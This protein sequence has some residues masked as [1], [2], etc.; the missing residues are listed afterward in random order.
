MNRSS[1]TR[2][3]RFLPI[4][5]SALLVGILA[6]PANAEALSPTP[7]VVQDTIRGTV[8]DADTRQPVLG[9]TV[10][11]AGTGVGTVT[12]AEGNY[13]LAAPADGSLI[14]SRI[15]YR[16]LEVAIA[17]RA[18]V[19]VVLDVSVAELQEL[20]VTGYTGQRRADIT[21]AVSS[22]N[23]ESAGRETSSSVLQRLHGNVPGVTVEASGTPGA[24]S[25]VRIRGISS[26]QNNNPLY[27][28]DGIPVEDSG[29]ANYLNP[30]DIESI[31]VLKDASA[32]SIYGSR[33]N[34]GV[35]IIE[36]KK[37]RP[38]PPRVSVDA[39]FG[40]ATPVRGYDSF[41]IQDA[42]EYHEV[43][44]LSHVNAGLEVPTNIF[45]DPNNPSLPAYTYVAPG[46]TIGTDE[47]GR[48]LA[49]EGMYA[50]PDHLIMPASAGTNWWDAVFGTAQV[51]DV[52]LRVSGGSS[53]ERYNVSFNYFDQEGT[54]AFTRFQRGTIRLNT[55]FNVGRLTVGE[56]LNLSLEEGFG[57]MSDPGGFAENTIIGKNMMMQPV[58]PVRDVAGNYASAKAIG[59][60]NHTNPL[61]LAESTKDNV[62]RHARMLGNAFARFDL[63]DRLLVNTRFGFNVGQ[64]MFRGFDDIFPENSEPVLSNRVFESQ[65][66]FLNWTW[67]NTLNYQESF[68]GVHNTSILVGQEANRNSGRSMGGEIR[69]LRFTTDINARYIQDAIGDPDTKN[70]SSGGGFSTLLSYF[71]K[72]DYNFDERYY[73]SF[74]L[75]H[76]GSS[77]LGPANRWGTFP[78]FS[79]G[80]RLS[81]EPFLERSTFFTNIMLRA[82]WGITGNQDI[83]A[84]RTVDR[85]GGSIGD[86]FYDID[87]SGNRVVLG[88]RQT[89]WGNP[90]LKWEENQSVNLG[91]DLEFLEG[92]AHLEL[93]VYQ[94]DTDNLL[95]NPPLPGTAGQAASRIVNIGKMSNRGIDFAIGY[96][97]TLG[98]DVDWHVNFNGA[99]YRNE[100]VRI[101]GQ[102][103]FFFGPIS[104]RFGTHAINMVGYPIGAFY[105]LILDG[106]FQ[107]Q[108]EIDALNER[109]RQIT[110]DPDAV[111][112]DGAAPGRFRFRD[113]TGDG[114][115]TA[116]DRTIIGDPHPDFTAGLNL[117]VRWNN[118]DLGASLFGTFGNDIFDVQ[119]EF[120][121]FRNFNSNV[122]RDVLSQ[123]AV[124]NEAG[125]VSNPD[126]KY[127]RL[128]VTDEFS[129]AISSFYVEDGSY[130]RLR[131]LQIGYTVPPGRF[132]GLEN[133][134]I[135][136]Q[137]ENLFTITGY[138]GLDPALPASSVSS[139]GMDIRDQARGIDRGAYPSNR[140]F[141]LGFGV[142]F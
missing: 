63:T 98:N 62:S 76:D 84:G 142:A 6:Y 117:G 91:L 28:I 108:A 97:G 75:R 12:D 66:T 88:F 100:V 118:W 5:V 30:N 49:D 9:V 55:E 106:I 107:N 138:S 21:G 50:W 40:M 96:R 67:S 95:F 113:V 60:G 78:A 125:E 126:A 13:S 32:A 65:S 25:T 127:P 109:A 114:R 110:G 37:G 7:G 86:T 24:R 3:T 129:R 59:L 1:S 135:Y 133:V 99:H 8:T 54:A 140:T 90:D 130:V 58:V 20:V 47:W 122:R 26:F 89:Q 132:P 16:A 121:V 17:G 72:V 134:R 45:G 83:A 124:L 71:G 111:Y 11:L 39:R 68:G 115:V 81:E 33:A 137:G 2:G 112:Q 92:R 64:G 141:T 27:I 80:W 139:A 74:T 31:Q 69:N 34:N 82:G 52:N 94:R 42:L 18:R 43:M 51:R 73:L 123:S 23:L 41:L 102:Q 136:V 120:Y 101:D 77:R 57:G 14:F 85:L 44:R 15:G 104:S 105:G 36:T 4:A 29:F 53:T 22:V 119:K 56:N 87:G 116:A 46:A 128:D 131:S 93:D 79:A 61:K 35:V 103:E 48:P 70:V 19:D 38:G 10:R